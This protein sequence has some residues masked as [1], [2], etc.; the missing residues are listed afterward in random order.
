[1]VLQK[2]NFVCKCVLKMDAIYIEKRVTIKTSIT[3]AVVINI[4]SK[5]SQ[6]HE[7]A[8]ERTEE[9]RILHLLMYVKHGLW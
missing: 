9:F 3:A 1:M 8:A 7:T 5:Q 2:K 6:V 4:C